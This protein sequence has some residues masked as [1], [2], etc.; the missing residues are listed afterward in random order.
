M[1]S[2]HVQVTI[3]FFTKYA[4][5]LLSEILKTLARVRRKM[6]K[7]RSVK[8]IS[9]DEAIRV[10]LRVLILRYTQTTIA[11]ALE[12]VQSRVSEIKN[13]KSSI[14]SKEIDSLAVLQEK[15]LSCVICEIAALMSRLEHGEKPEQI[16]AKE[17]EN[18]DA[19]GRK[20][21]ASVREIGQ[22]AKDSEEMSDK[23]RKKWERD[24]EDS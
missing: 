1:K 9:W 13:A 23:I 11:T 4:K 14:A 6:R 24:D 2:K 8:R 7:P 18:I 22:T 12:N 21:A 10:Y 16:I 19:P 20:R 15:P 3:A 17:R 5:L